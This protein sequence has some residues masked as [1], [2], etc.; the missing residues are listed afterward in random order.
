MCLTAYG[1]DLSLIENVWP[2][3]DSGKHA[4]VPT[5]LECVAGTKIN[6]Y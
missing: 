4:S 3:C 6:I 5:F 2:R 1:P